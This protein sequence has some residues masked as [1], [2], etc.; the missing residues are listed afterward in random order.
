MPQL[1]RIAETALYVDDLERAS[2][3]YETVLECRALL[4]TPTLIAYDIGGAGVLLLFKRGGARDAQA[5]P[6]GTIPGHDGAGPVHI[7]FGIESAD[8][9]AW[10]TR[11]GEHG[12]GIEGRMQWERGGTS[13]YF[14][15][16]DAHLLELMTP[17]NWP[18]Y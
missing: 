11:L 1:N 5:L 4:R 10:E 13:L 7:C 6:G 12:V 2:R 15:D 17:G 14:R 8:L 9:G 3:F 18:G 16:P